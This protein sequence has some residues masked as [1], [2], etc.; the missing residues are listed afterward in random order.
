[1]SSLPLSS[2]CAADRGD[3][4]GAGRRILL[5]DANSFYCSCEQVFD[6]ALVGKPL[7]VLSNSDG[8]VVARSAQAKE[9]GVKMGQP[10]F[11]LR[12]LAARK[13]PD[14]LLARSSNYALYGDMSAR[15]VTILR[16]FA[17]AVE[18]YS[19]DE[20]FLDLGSMRVSDIAAHGHA[21]RRRVG[22]WLGLPVCVGAGPTKTLAKMANHLAK[23]QPRWQGV[24]DLT[25][26]SAADLDRVWRLISIFY[27]VIVFSYFFV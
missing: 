8:C 9:L 11:E 19:I 17:P 6:A 22:R 13:G 4:V 24:C 21:I 20:S 10:W 15:M 27:K 18:V 3:Q 1:M 16:G 12:A 25:R 7:V 2:S 23:K 26:L 14:R 5:V